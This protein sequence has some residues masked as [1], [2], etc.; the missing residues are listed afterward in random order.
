MSSGVK[1]K[2]AILEKSCITSH[3]KVKSIRISEKKSNLHCIRSDTTKRVTSGGVH[4]RSLA[5]E[6]SSFEETSSGG[7]WS[8]TLCLI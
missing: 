1:F 4:L 3:V 8:A 2:V 6:Q 7:D 5:P